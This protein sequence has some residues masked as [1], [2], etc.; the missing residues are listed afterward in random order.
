LGRML[1]SSFC[2]CTAVKSDN[3]YIEKSIFFILNG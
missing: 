3:A 1:L 2:A